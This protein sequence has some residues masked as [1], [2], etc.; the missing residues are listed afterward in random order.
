MEGG[1]YKDLSIRKARDPELISG[2]VISLR[3]WNKPST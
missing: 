1:R 2:A 3:S